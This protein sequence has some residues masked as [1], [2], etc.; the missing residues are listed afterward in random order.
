MLIAGVLPEGL[1]QHVYSVHITQ[2]SAKPPARQGV[3][4]SA[5]ASACGGAVLHEREMCNIIGGSE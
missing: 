5:R 3:S 2:E 1:E 4:R